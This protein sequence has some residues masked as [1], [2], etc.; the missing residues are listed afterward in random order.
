MLENSDE[1]SLYKNSVNI[2]AISTNNSVSRITDPLS[3]TAFS[4]STPVLPPKTPIT[5]GLLTPPPSTPRIKPKQ[6]RY[7]LLSNYMDDDAH[8]AIGIYGKADRLRRSIRIRERHPYGG[9]KDFKVDE[10]K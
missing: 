1:I 10:E 5:P 3:S 2:P 6:P 9:F 4:S 8:K 7:D